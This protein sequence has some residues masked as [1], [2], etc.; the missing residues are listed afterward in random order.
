M[1]LHLLA[2]AVVLTGSLYAADPELVSLAM[3]DAQVMAGFNS[4][5]IRLSPFGQYLVNQI[6]AI[7]DKNFQKLIDT[8]GF[9]PR[10]DLREILIAAPSL[11]S[12]HGTLFLARGTFDIPRIVEAATAAGADAETYQGVNVIAH[13]KD[14]AIAFPDS[15]IAIA[16]EPPLVHA[17]IDRKSAPTSIGAAL[18]VQVNQLSNSE[19]AWFVSL[20][21]MT[22]LT[23]PS[24]AGP[25]S[26][27]FAGVQQIC[28]GLKF[29]A[30]IALTVQAV[31]A[32]DQDAA[33]LAA[34]LKAAGI[35][36]SGNAQE[37]LAQ[38]AFAL[39]KTMTVT[40]DGKTTTASLSV[41]ETQLE[42]MMK[43]EP[44]HVAAETAPPP[45][46]GSRIAGVPEGPAA[47][48]QRIRVGREV[49]RAKLIQ[50]VPPV[51]PPLAKQARISGVVYLNA[52]I[53]MAGNVQNLTVESGHPLLVPAAMEAAKQWLYQPTLLNGRPVE[54]VTQLKVDFQLEQ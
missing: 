17:A 4:E 46:S 39:L 19:D 28:G 49:Q 50:Q 29:G 7:P 47:V 35:G 20:S 48:P 3:P 53:G 14:L 5:Q 30:D 31:S 23:L 11:Q 45:R 9:D 52:I 12:A 24:G 37:E 18:A 34:L 8:T 1:R 21:P 36:I 27:L 43:A 15:T 25:M 6:G 32:T 41:P 51:Y 44:K 54:V 33:T 40:T 16:G 42:K 38:Q 2:A 26:G 22:Q 13:G 10:R